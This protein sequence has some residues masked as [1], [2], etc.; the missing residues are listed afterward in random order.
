MPRSRCSGRQMREQTACE[1]D[2]IVSRCVLSQYEDD[3]KQSIRAAKKD[4]KSQALR[5]QHAYKS[6]STT[7]QALAPSLWLSFFRFHGCHW[8]RWWLFESSFA[9]LRC[10][11]SFRRVL[12][13]ARKCSVVSL[14]HCCPW[15]A[16]EE[17][18]RTTHG[19]RVKLHG[20]R[21]STNNVWLWRH[22]SACARAHHSVVGG[23]GRAEHRCLRRRVDWRSRQGRDEG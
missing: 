6:L 10:G 9:Y 1:S 4:F 21:H 22:E 12:L 8:L 2:R 16:A 14:R 19:L 18:H 23:R 7:E 20:R 17:R 15:R 3:T 11:V 13:F 5:K